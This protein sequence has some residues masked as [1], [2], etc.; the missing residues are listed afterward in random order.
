[1]QAV[2][3]VA[4]GGRYNILHKKYNAAPHLHAGGYWYW[5][6]YYVLQ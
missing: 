1:M 5:K 3:V 4:K 2:A 6:R